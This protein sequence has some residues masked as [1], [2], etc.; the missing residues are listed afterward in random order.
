MLVTHLAFVLFVTA[1]GLLVFRWPRVAALHLPCLIYG[2]AIE[3]VGWIC[4]LTPMEQR[5]RRLA[6]HAGY[7]GGFIE[8]YASSLLYPADWE[9]LRLWLGGSLLVFN[10]VIYALW[11]RRLRARRDTA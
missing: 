4:P 7:E 8:H 6:G 11:L 2:A 9:A 3:L 10:F 5:L 1:G